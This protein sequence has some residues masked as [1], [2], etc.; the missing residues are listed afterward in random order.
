MRLIATRLYEVDDGE[1]AVDK[2]YRRGDVFALHLSA[3]AGD[4]GGWTVYSA[5]Q[6]REWLSEAPEQLVEVREAV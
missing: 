3:T 1:Q 4:P 6:A 2:L 5:E